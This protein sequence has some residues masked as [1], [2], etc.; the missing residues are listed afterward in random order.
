MRDAREPLRVGSKSC[1]DCHAEF[2]KRWSTSHHGLA[3]QPYTA[4]LGRE[5]LGPQA[6]P[7][8]IRGR[9][10][11]YEDGA[12]H[13]T[14][15][16]GERTYKI[17][18]VMGGKNICY[19][20]TPMERG[21][22]QVLPLA[23][24]LRKK[25]WYDT[26][27]SGLRHFPDRTDEALDWT[28]RMFTFNST[29]FNCHVSE[30]RTNYDAATDTYHT[31]WTEPGISCEACHGP[32]EKH[33]ALMNERE[34]K[35]L[36]TAGGD[37]AILR[38]KELS[39]Q[40]TNDLCATCHAKLVP[41]APGFKPG[42]AF[43]DHFDLVALEHPDFYPDGRD[44]GENY[45]MGTW[46][47]SACA[48][49]GKLDCNH[50]HTPSGRMKFAP[51]QTNQA[52]LPCH[53]K[54]V[55]DPAAHGHHDPKGKGNDCTGCHMPM[56]RFAAM[57]RSDHSMRP[58]MPKATAAFG[59]P[60]ACNLCHADKDAAWAQEWCQKWYRPDYQDETLRRGELIAA[61]RRRDYARLREMLAEL[62]RRDNGEFYRASLVRL[63]RGD[64]PEARGAL[65]AAL[66]DPSPLVRG[67]AAAG[68]TGNFAPDALR[69]LLSAAGDESRL[70]RLRAALALASL[71]PGQI[72][73]ADA[74]RLDRA[75][76]E[77]LTA[78]HARSDDWSSYANLGTF[79]L[80]RRDFFKAVENF[81]RAVRIEPRMVTVQIN[82]AIAYSNIERTDRAEQCL[83]A[84][85]KL[86]P[87]SAEALFNLGLL[88]GEQGK[89]AEA[90]ASLKAALKSDPQMAPAAY[91]LG[92]LAADRDLGEAISW[93]EK[94]HE[95]APA[96]AKYAYTLA[97]YLNKKGDRERAA[98]VLR[99]AIERAPEAA[100]LKELLRQIL[101]QGE[102]K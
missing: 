50:C 79:Y 36:K 59:S 30:I 60:N 95:L 101:G 100:E 64:E 72:G 25:A 4:E 7:V 19:F 52:C 102:G 42:S 15:P 47:Q 23:Y 29:C 49:S 20:L 65:V 10:Y 85:L 57:G 61:A 77:F 70:V 55:A 68:L 37:I 24:D 90:E 86:D 91:N 5:R 32:G 71:P 16:Q 87:A 28:D 3:M 98:G 18:Q 53:E 99:E 92:V 97:F 93:C 84:A 11:R 62:K 83:R 12:I 14:S 6:E 43:Y 26:A 39:A 80:G 82:L 78:M 75:T 66:E 94:A 54:Y 76:D 22:L 17:T 1:R 56:T 45:T 9:K 44:L 31:T 81:E 38:S 41:L 96:D 51:E 46:L 48:A 74:R 2:Y 35:G 13:E 40:Q 89:K 27:A 34:A 58:P 8:E 69:G 63:L 33:V 88:Q 21:R 73:A 67:S